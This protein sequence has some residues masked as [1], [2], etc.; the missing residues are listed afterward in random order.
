MELYQLCLPKSESTPTALYIRTE[1]IVTQVANH[2]KLAYDSAVSFDT[3]FG[4][5]DYLQ[6]R[7]YTTLTTP[8]AAFFI[9]GTMLVKCYVRTAERT[10]LLYE[11]TVISDGSQPQVFPFSISNLRKTAF[12]IFA[13]RQNQRTAYFC[14]AAIWQM[15]QN[16]VP[17]K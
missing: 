11:Q 3:W 14:V 4:C 9:K 5:F 13:C 1:G 15:F 2:L 12:C 7:R 10:S 6:W 8:I 16:F 17:F